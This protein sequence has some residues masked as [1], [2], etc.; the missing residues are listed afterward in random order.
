MCSWAS[1]SGGF[2]AAS[3]PFSH[4][5]RCGIATWNPNNLH[6]EGFEMEDEAL[7]N[8]IDGFSIN[9]LVE[10]YMMLKDS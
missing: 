6:F 2:E 1:G 9:E 4:P 10:G 5:S 8:I 7:L 3:I